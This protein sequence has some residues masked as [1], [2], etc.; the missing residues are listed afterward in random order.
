MFHINEGLGFIDRSSE[1][2]G[3]RWSVLYDISEQC[4]I[5]LVIN[6]PSIIRNTKKTG[7]AFRNRTGWKK[8]EELFYRRGDTLNFVYG[9]DNTR[10]NH[11][12]VDSIKQRP[13]LLCLCFLWKKIFEWAKGCHKELH[14]WVS[15]SV[16]KGRKQISCSYKLLVFLLLCVYGNKITRDFQSSWSSL[17]VIPAL[18]ARSVPPP[19]E[20]LQAGTLGFKVK[21]LFRGCCHGSF[22]VT[23]LQ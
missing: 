11:M 23:R 22:L 5:P 9:L 12:K 19:L 7:P 6:F 13:L 21:A 3:S 4:R 18:R 20:V 16:L 17:L 8:R 1:C 10:M 2:R 15:V 14:S